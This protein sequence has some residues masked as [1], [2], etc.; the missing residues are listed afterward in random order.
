MRCRLKQ[1]S[2]YTGRSPLGLK[3]TVVSLPHSAQTT[4]CISREFRL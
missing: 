3:G 2:Q 4:G 1:S